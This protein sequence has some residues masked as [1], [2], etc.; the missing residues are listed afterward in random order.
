M[1]HFYHISLLI[2]LPSFYLSKYDEYRVA[3][4]RKLD[5]LL[6]PYVARIIRTLDDQERKLRAK[7]QED[8]LLI[9]TRQRGD[10]HTRDLVVV[11]WLQIYLS[12]QHTGGE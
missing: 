8:R 6:E 1:L 3:Y 12:I 2:A 10:W 9:K 7:L 4:L 5:E 11:R